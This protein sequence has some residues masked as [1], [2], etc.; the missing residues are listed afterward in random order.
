MCLG[1]LAVIPSAA[2]ASPQ[3]TYP[4]G[5]RLATGSTLKATNV[6]V[7]TV[8]RTDGTSGGNCSA[9]SLTGSLVKN[10]GT[11]V[12]AN[13]EAASF[14][15]T[16]TEGRCTIE[17]MWT[18]NWKFTFGI[19][20]GLPWCLV[21]NS[22]MKEDEFQIRGGKCSETS[23]PIY[24]ALDASGGECKYEAGSFRGTFTT[25]PSDTVLTV[26]TPEYPL[27]SG[28]FLCPALWRLDFSLTLERDE[29]GTHPVYI[30]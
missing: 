13:I 17:S 6:G 16:G 11:E 22:L 9:A 21:A 3:L 1:V 12:E 5:T 8:T 26:S 23:R 10:N 4:T 30:S 2:F 19:E 25:E 24:L 14:T 20:K 15:G 7:I 29:A 18:G 27:V 28:S